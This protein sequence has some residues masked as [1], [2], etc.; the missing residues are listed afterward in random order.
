ME[1]AQSEWDDKRAKT[2]QLIVDRIQRGS[3]ACNIVSDIIKADIK[4]NKLDEMMQEL[5]NYF[6]SRTQAGLFDVIFSILN[7]PNTIDESKKHDLAYLVPHVYSQFARLNNFVITAAN[8]AT[9]ASAV[10][11]KLLF[12]LL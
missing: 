4:G 2:F 12:C 3:N 9:G 6:N 5:K 8:P 7:L 10:T 11:C 1:Q